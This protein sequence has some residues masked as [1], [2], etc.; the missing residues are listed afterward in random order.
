MGVGGAARNPG[1]TSVLESVTSGTPV[2]EPP[3]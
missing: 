3:M 1:K 2:A